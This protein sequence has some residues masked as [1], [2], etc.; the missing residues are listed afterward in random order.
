MQ[1]LAR[2]AEAAEEEV[3]APAGQQV[4]E[5]ASVAEA[6]LASGSPVTQAG[7]HGPGSGR[8]SSTSNSPAAAGAAANRM[9]PPLPFASMGMS[10]HVSLGRASR[11]VLDALTSAAKAVPTRRPRLL[12]PTLKRKQPA[13]AR[14]QQQ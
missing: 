1:S 4:Q 11:V 13:G 7:E 6:P 12:R 14:P 8:S 3:A 2:M 9:W 10:G 5:L